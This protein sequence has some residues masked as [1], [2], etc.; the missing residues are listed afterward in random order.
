MCIGKVPA[1]YK[2]FED[3]MD[4]CQCFAVVDQHDD[5]ADVPECGGNPTFLDCMACK[6]FKGLGCCPHVLAINHILGEFNVKHQLKQLPKKKEKDTRR[7]GNLKAPPK[8]LQRVTYYPTD[9]EDEQE[10]EENE[11]ED[12]EE[13]EGEEEVE[14]EEEEEEEE[15]QEEF[16]H[17][18]SPFSD[19]D[20]D[21]E[22][23]EQER[24]EAPYG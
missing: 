23:D 9:D 1:K 18:Y 14:E 3:L 4:L 11:E 24:V 12:D 7:G 22:E 13:E 21:N 20:P 15:E 8:A 19:D 10:E 17:P 2:K 16:I 6:C 5:R